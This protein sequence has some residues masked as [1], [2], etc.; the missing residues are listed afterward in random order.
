MLP[1]IAILG[2]SGFVGRRLLEWFHL[3][4]SAELRPIVR[5][6]SSLASLSRF[7]LDWRIAD[8]CDEVALAAAFSGCDY[9]VNLI[10]ANPDIIVRNAAISYRAAETAFVKRMVFMSSASVHGQAPSP[11]TN[12]ASLLHTSHVF[13]YNNAK[14]IAE[15]KLFGLRNSGSVELS[16]LRPGIVYGPRSRWIRDVADQLLSDTAYL[17]DGGMGICNSIYVDNLIHAIELAISLPDADRN[18][19]LVGDLERV[20]WLDFYKFIAINLG[21]DMSRV[22]SIKPIIYHHGFSD[23][24]NQLRVSK[25]LQAIL[26]YVP[27][28]VKAALKAGVKSFTAQSNPSPWAF[29]E[30]QQYQV[31]EEINALH[32]CSVQ[33]PSHKANSLLGFQPPIP[34]L[35][36]MRRSCAWLHFAGYSTLPQHSPS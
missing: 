3:T 13:P 17:V 2:A 7:D 11:G 12:E 22:K 21:L 25:P 32:Q 36:G 28:P 16:I 1:K 26:P 19:F 20:T 29:N 5:N 10:A 23:R 9:V 31:S 30:I 33:L 24:F 34:F 18:V 15:R 4:N 35:E 27:T 8:A 14:V 6:Y